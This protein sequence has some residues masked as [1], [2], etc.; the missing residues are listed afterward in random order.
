LRAVPDRGYTVEVFD[1]IYD[2]DVSGERVYAEK[3]GKYIDICY[4]LDDESAV[5]VFSAFEDK[6]T[7][8]DYYILAQNGNYVY[9]VTDKKTFR[10]SGFESTDNVGTQYIN[11]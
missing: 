11:E 9:C 8:T 4:G 2:T 10:N 5:S 1:R 3:N 7:D 6:Y